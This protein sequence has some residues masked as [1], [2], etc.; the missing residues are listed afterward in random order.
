[1]EFVRDND[2]I[3]DDAAL[4]ELL[5]G[6]LEAFYQPRL[7]YHNWDEHIQDGL[8]IARNLMEQ[9]TTKGRPI[10]TLMG[11]VAYMGH[12]AGFPHDL[13]EEKGKETWQP[14]GSKEGYSA[15]IMRRLLT[16]YGC[17]EAFIDGV[18]T[19]IMYT[20]MGNELP[21]GV[22]EEV[23]NTAEAVRTADLS[24]VF[25][26][27]KGFVMNS[28]KLMEEDRVYKRERDLSE[29]K[30]ITKFVLTNFLS[31]EFRPAG[32]CRTVDG[33]KN[34]ERFMK[35]SPSRL[36]RSVGSHASRFAELVRKDAA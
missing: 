18:T 1:M 24:N 26:P 21:E 2:E 32:A 3:Q 15:H 25:G 17:D 28:F 16:N 14:Y 31:L 9:E 29:F 22:S 19:C 5:A 27:Y 34:I 6:D 10:N 23:A 33:M 35:D 7:P 11:L 12:D 8:V 13:G 30:K 36:L 4:L 20:Q